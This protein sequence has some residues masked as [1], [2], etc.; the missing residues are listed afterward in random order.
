MF[1]GLGVL[2][3]DVCVCVGDVM[4]V[5]F[6]VCIVRRGAVAG[7]LY[8][9]QRTLSVYICERTQTRPTCSAVMD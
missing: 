4:D 1:F 5:V 9:G 2:K 6:S 7:L 3:Y 8:T